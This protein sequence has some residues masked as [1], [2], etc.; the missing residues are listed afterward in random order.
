M[1]MGASSGIRLNKY[2]ASIGLASRRK[3]TELIKKEKVKVNNLITI[4]PGVKINPQ[5]DKIT[6]DGND[7]VSKNTRLTYLILNKPKGIISTASDEMGRKTVL[8]L[9]NTKDRLYPV[10]RLDSESVGLILL[11]ND[12]EL[13]NKLTHPRYHINKTYH[14]LITGKVPQGKLNTLRR[15]VILKDG[16]T[17]SA[18]VRIVMNNIKSTLFEIVL[19]EGKNRQIRRMCAALKLNIISLK[20]VAIGPIELGNLKPGESRPLTDAEI[21]ILKEHAS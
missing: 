10:G 7:I 16:K 2:L 8:S 1:N 4:E 9:V 17:A 18:E 20:R 21:A 19:H 15:G 14:V 12:G 11:T 6:F 5:K 13:T 3:I